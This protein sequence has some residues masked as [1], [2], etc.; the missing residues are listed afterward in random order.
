MDSLIHTRSLAL[1][2]VTEGD[3]CM[4][5][6]TTSVPG[7]ACHFTRS[8]CQELVRKRRFMRNRK[9][10]TGILLLNVPW[11]FPF[12]YYICKKGF[13]RLSL[14]SFNNFCMKA[15]A[16]I[17]YNCNKRKG[18]TS[19]Y[20][21]WLIIMKEIVTMTMIGLCEMSSLSSKFFSVRSKFSDVS[22][23]RP[24]LCTEDDSRMR[25]CHFTIKP[26]RSPLSW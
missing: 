1:K 22:L 4:S 5:H 3:S 9:Q 19:L 16:K 26:P 10:H 18:N 13:D 7:I 2:R 14:F 21:I 17:K 15:K 23:F 12:I 24:N 8:H 6:P 20:E 11:Q 25:G